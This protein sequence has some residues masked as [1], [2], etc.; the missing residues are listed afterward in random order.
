[1]QKHVLVLVG[2]VC[3]VFGCSGGNKVDIEA[4]KAAL[5]QAETDWAATLAAKDLDGFLS[6]FAPDAVVL[7]PHLPAFTGTDAIREW[8]TTSFS[9]PGFAV[10]W[11]TTAVEVAASGDMGYTLGNFTFH[12]EMDGTPLDD[13]GKYVTNWKKQADGSWKVVVDAFN[14]D[15]EM[16]PAPAGAAPGDTTGAGH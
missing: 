8:A 10:T 5:R 15:I 16:M 1:M 11:T 9:F 2:L 4:E 13:H 6:Y 12:V 3:V 14:S 7:G